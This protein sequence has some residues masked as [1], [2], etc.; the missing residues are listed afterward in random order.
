MDKKIDWPEG[1][2]FM[3]TTQQGKPVC[4]YRNVKDEG[5]EF[6]YPV[7]DGNNWER[8]EGRKPL[9]LPLIPRPAEP[10][11]AIKTLEARIIER[12]EQR[13]Q[14]S[15]EDAMLKLRMV[16]GSEVSDM[17]SGINGMT[18]REA[19]DAVGAAIVRLKAPIAASDALDSALEELADRL[20]PSRMLAPGARY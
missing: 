8:A 12:A 18:V 11:P 1:A 19:I 17:A 9:H 7:S 5:F 20:E 6:L 15:V 16:A 14:G 3:G 4:F 2:E 13:L 10:V